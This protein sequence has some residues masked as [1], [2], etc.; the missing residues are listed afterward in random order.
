MTSTLAW[1]LRR[2]KNRL[3]PPMNMGTLYDLQN[4]EGV[5]R[6]YRKE[7]FVGTSEIYDNLIDNVH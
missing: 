6:S 3:L 5:R 7:L 1:A 4:E 2:S